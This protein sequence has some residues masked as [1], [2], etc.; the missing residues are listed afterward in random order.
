MDAYAPASVLINDKREGLHFFGPTD[1]YLKIASGDASHDILVMA[2]EGL[3]GK[4]RVAIQRASDDQARTLVTGARVMRDGGPVAVNITVLPVVSEGE[5]LLLVSFTDE[6]T[7]EPSAQ[8]DLSNQRPT[9]PGS[10]ELEQELESMRGELSGA[11]RELEIANEEHKA[12]NE[13]AMSVNEEFQSTNEELETSKEELQSLNEELSA[14]NSQLQETVERQRETSDDLNN[15]L[16]SSDV[17]TLFLDCDSENSLLH[18]R[19]EGAVQHHRIRY[20]AAARRLDAQVQ[21][22]RPVGRCA[23]GARDTCSVPA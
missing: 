15:I 1:R 3:R 10:F 6:A 21:R 22:Q 11:V 17:A 20:R 4:L 12:I 18:A 16:N 2:R 8:S 7:R 9:C 14:L 5:R 19:R 23:N 13:E